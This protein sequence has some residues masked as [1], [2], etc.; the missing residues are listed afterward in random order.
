MA[1]TDLRFPS[2][3]FLP[4]DPRV[5]EPYRLSPQTAF[6]IGIL[7]ALALAAFA[8]LFLR[9]WS[10]QVLSGDRYL[11]AAQNNQVRTLP[12]EAPRGAILDRNGHT[13]VTNKPGTAVRIWVA[14]LPRK[15]RYQ[16]LRE[17]AGV[18]NVPLLE[19]AA[20]VERQKRDPLTP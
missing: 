2:R 15:N 19:I 18:L 20:K 8:I 17:L 10:L 7:G 12:L 11:V 9:L 3:R 13:L 1:S 5:S 4:G 6:R 14:D 16:E